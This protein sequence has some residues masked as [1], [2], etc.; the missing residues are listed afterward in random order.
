MPKYS[1][2]FHQIPKEE[3]RDLSYYDRLLKIKEQKEQLE[4]EEY[5]KNY[6]GEPPTEIQ[7]AKSDE[8][9]C[10]VETQLKIKSKKKEENQKQKS[11]L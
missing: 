6:W 8:F 2:T 3:D 7:K 9:K 5:L 1:S 4:R 10:K 11:N